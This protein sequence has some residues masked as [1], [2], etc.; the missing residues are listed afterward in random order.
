[1]GGGLSGNTGLEYSQGLARDGAESGRAWG[2]QATS[3]PGACPISVLCNVAFSAPLTGGGGVG[4]R[5][6]TEL[7]VRSAFSSQAGRRTLSGLTCMG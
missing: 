1:M 5:C 6:H 2:F 3:L 7:P 4:G